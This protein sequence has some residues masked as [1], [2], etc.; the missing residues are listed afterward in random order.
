[1]LILA[2]ALLLLGGDALAVTSTGSVTS[3]LGGNGHNVSFDGRV[4]VIR[5][6]GGWHR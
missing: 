3:A 1:M 4:Y 6:S 5:T 2:T